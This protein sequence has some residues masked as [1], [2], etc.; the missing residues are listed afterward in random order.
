MGWNPKRVR[1][2]IVFEYGTCTN[3]STEAEIKEHIR[4]EVAK[5]LKSGYVSPCGP[6]VFGIQYIASREVEVVDRE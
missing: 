2:Q 4:N 5:A 1:V 6:N 3:A